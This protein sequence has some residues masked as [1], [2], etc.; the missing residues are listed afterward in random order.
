MTPT[1]ARAASVVFVMAVGIAVVQLAL[2]GRVETW[3][4]GLI[5]ALLIGGGVLLLS[6]WGASSGGGLRAESYR[7]GRNSPIWRLYW[8][9]VG[10]IGVFFA[11]GLLTDETVAW[12]LVVVSGVVSGVTGLMVTF[13]QTKQGKKQGR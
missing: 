1:R 12:V 13:P 8:M 9:S 11:L 4:R 3:V 5:H 10:S 2:D 7:S 6:R